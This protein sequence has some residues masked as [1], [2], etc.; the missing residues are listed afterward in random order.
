VIILAITLSCSSL[1]LGTA[2]WE[3][4]N[5]VSKRIDWTYA[6]LADAQK[7]AGAA[8]FIGLASLFTW[9]SL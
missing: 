9:V 1:V 4:F 6:E 5:D 3:E 2:A 8:G 7:L